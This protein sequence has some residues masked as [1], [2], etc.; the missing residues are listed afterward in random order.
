LVEGDSRER[1]RLAFVGEIRVTGEDG[2]SLQGLVGPGDK[3]RR[4]LER[5]GPVKPGVEG[6]VAAA[7]GSGQ[8]R[9]S[10]AGVLRSIAVSW[11]EFLVEPRRGRDETGS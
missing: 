8:R 11:M 4:R 9:E 10:F 7:K 1:R 2:A 6:G 5:R 3:G